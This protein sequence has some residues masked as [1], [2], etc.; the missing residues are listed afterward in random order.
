MLIGVSGKIGS[1]K[2]T[3]ASILVGKLPE[4]KIKNFADK[5]KVITSFLTN[6]E[7][8][9]MYSEE[10]KNEY[11]PEWEMTVGEFQQ[12]LGTEGMRNSIH[13][14][15]WVIALLSEYN[16]NKDNWVIADV[17]F[18]NEAQAIQNKNGILIKIMGDPAN[19]RKNSKRNHLH[20]SE[21][22]L[23]K[24]E[25]WDYTILNVPPISKLEE[26]IDQ[27]IQYP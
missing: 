22:A 12:K 20:E 18:P 16:K 10:G 25:K 26:Q 23:D 21:I 24:W 14:D 11:L 17:R 3:V 4:Y 1:G 15:G 8:K 2:S 9:N 7:L 13:K 27:I 6:K 5:L 19:A